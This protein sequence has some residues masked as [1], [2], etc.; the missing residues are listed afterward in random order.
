[1]ESA[2]GFPWTGD[3]NK[4]NTSE[5]KLSAF[6]IL[7]KFFEATHRAYWA[8]WAHEYGHTLGIP[9]ISGSR[10]SS[11]FQSYDMMGN[12]DS[13]RELS[14]WSR[15]AVTKWLEDEWVFC[16]EKRSIKSEFVNLSK[17]NSKDIGFKMAVIP[18]SST[19]ALIAESRMSSKFSGSDSIRGRTDGVLVYI[20]DATLGHNKE[21]LTP[22][23][24]DS[25]PILAAG[26]SI[27]YEGI[28]IKVISLGTQDKIQ[29][30]QKS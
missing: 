25:D 15:F 10:T 17:L 21:Y 28:S 3:I 30:T 26:E 4:H 19:K 24:L 9:H 11:T 12:Q 1:M 29:I 16:K 18:L 8:Y 2:Q 14:G 27:T 13:R 7:G 23:S 20:Y 22:A 6:T 5:G